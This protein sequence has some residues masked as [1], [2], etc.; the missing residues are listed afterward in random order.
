MTWLAP[1]G[2]FWEQE[3]RSMEELWRERQI[4]E[5]IWALR[6]QPDGDPTVTA[7]PTT[8]GTLDNFGEVRIDSIVLPILAELP[9]ADPAIRRPSLKILGQLANDHQA[10]QHHITNLRAMGGTKDDFFYTLQNHGH[11]L[12]FA[13]W[14]YRHWNPRKDRMADKRELETLVDL[15]DELAEAVARLPDDTGGDNWTRVERALT[16]YQDV[17]RETR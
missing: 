4:A 15:A 14:K 13:R 11:R 3:H 9:R 17:R 1:S 2:D 6:K 5:N 16:K 8:P 10:L 7:D 12:L